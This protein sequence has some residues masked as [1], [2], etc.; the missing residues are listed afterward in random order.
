[1][2]PPANI[3][4]KLHGLGPGQQHAEIERVQEAVL[5]DPALLVDEDAMHQRDLAGRAAE[6]QHAD[7]RP[8][9]QGLFERGRRLLGHGREGAS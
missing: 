9:G 1:V 6:R 3:G 4:R 2:Q 5:G 8:D 7:F